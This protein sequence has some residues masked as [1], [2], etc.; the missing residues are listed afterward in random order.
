MDKCIDSLRDARVFSTLEC[1]AAYWQMP[2]AEEDKHLT[3]FTCH[4]GA[5]QCVRLPVG[6]CNAPATFQRAMDMILAGEKWQI[7]LVYLDDVIVFSRSPEEHLQHLDEVLT[8]LGKAGVTLKARKCHFFQEEVEYLGHVIRPGRV[9]VLGKNLRAL[10]GLRY[11]ETQTQMKSFLGMRGVYRRFVADF[12]K[13]AKT[14]TALTNTKL[15]KKLPPPSGKETDAF[16]ILGG[17]LLDAPILAL[18]KR[19]GQYIVDV[20]ASYEQLGCC[21][22]QQQSDGEYHPI[23]YYSRAHLPAEKKYF[24]TQI[25]ALGVV[26]AVTYLRSYLEGAEFVVR[27]DH[28]ALLSVLINMSPNARINR[29]RIRLSEYNYEIRHK[30]GKDYKVADALSRLP[31]EGLDTSPLDED[32]PVLAVET[33]ASDALKRS[34]IGGGPYGGPVSPRHHPGPG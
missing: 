25:E 16:E 11:S 20:D 31:T 32:I 15:P 24:A 21:L 2:V 9:H 34:G 8:L 14:L 10:R 22:Q 28:R 33:R 13:I 30:P 17:R 18:P 12:A 3:A 19:H 7:C 27:C 1:N 4:S 26:W 29:W 6:L 23:G 5:W